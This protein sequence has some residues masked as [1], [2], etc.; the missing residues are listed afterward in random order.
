MTTPNDE[1]DSALQRG[2]VGDHPADLGGEP[3][4]VAGR[5]DVTGEPV[6]TPV[7]QRLPDADRRLAA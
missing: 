5:H 4:G 3:P 1:V 2:G 6:H 7:T